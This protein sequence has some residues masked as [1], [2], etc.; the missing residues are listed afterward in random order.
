M[1]ANDSFRCY[2]VSKDAAGKASSQITSQPLASLPQGDVL[3]RVAYSSLNYKDGLSATGNPG[4]TRNYPH[5]PG[6]DAAGTVAESSSPDWKPG[7][8]VIVT[9]YE[10][11]AGRWG[12]YAEYVRAPADWV[13]RLP[14]GMSLRESMVMGT[15][16]FT[17]A[18][19]VH[20]LVKHGI[21]PDAGEIVVTG[22]SGGVG[23]I[24]VALLAKLGYNVT[25]VSGKES[26]KELLSKL[27]AKQIIGRAEVDD[28]SGKPMLGTRWAGAVDTVGG[29]TLGTIL[30][31]TKLRGCVT[32]C[33]LV[34][35]TDLPMTVFPFILRGV[36]L[37]GI[38]SA[39]CPRAERQEIWNL[40]ANEWR[41]IGLE[42]ITREIGWGAL[43]GAVQEILAGQVT[44]RIVVRADASN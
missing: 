33:G 15:A 21:K 9:S 38:D 40:L 35:G 7:D 3:I 36:A 34:G 24:A 39:W 19:S 6:I 18:Q 16:G 28:R 11:G 13:V 41:L 23:S 1:S 22:A 26:S 12:G 2:L 42:S 8:E 4:V 32:A 37:A 30:R 44:G 27:G 43:D 17:A 10:L 25:A 20:A 5:I 29:N 14:R 31:S